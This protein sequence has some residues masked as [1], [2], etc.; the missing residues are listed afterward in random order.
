MGVISFPITLPDAHDIEQFVMTPKSFV[1]RAQSPFTGAQVVQR[2][3][4]QVL[5]AEIT[6]SPM[7][8]TGG[9]ADWQA[10]LASLNGGEGTFVM[11]DP[12]AG[13]PRGSAATSAGLPAAFGSGQSGDCL[14]IYAAPAS[15]TNYLRKGDWIGLGSGS[16]ARMHMVLRDVNTVSGG[17]A[18]LAIFPTLRYSPVNNAP[19]AVQSA[20]TQW[21]LAGNDFS[22]AEQ[23]VIYTGMTFSVIESLP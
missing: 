11:G 5:M 8:R 4:G 22:W 13:V 14:V 17:I 21:R 12:S 3:P 18:S 2:F 23:P 16:T 9:A 1:S 19:V 10:F 20:Q 7:P 15:V 6:L